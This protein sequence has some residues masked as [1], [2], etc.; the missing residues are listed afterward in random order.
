MFEFNNWIDVMPAIYFG[1]LGL[2]F[3]FFLCCVAAVIE[4]ENENRRKK[5]EQR[6]REKLQNKCRGNDF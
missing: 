1:F 3:L 5:K 4:I 6:Q 2:I